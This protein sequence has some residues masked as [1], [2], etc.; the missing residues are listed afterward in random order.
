MDGVT[1]VVSRDEITP[2]RA[3]DT[4]ATPLEQLATDTDVQRMVTRVLD[5]MGE[6]RVRVASFQAS[7]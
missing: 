5:N 6:S 2:E 1:S 4:R 7:I 3:L